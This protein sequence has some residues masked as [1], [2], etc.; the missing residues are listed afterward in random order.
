MRIALV[1]PE[2][3]ENLA[4]RYLHAAVERAGHEARI[5][6]FH[7]A[8]QAEQLAIDIAEYVPQLVGLSM[9]FTAR[10]KEFLALAGRLRAL[11]FAGHITAGGHFAAFHAQ[12]L[13]Q[14]F[15]ALDSVIQGEGEEALVELASQAPPGGNTG[16]TPPDADAPAPT[17]SA[18]CTGI[19]GLTWRDGA[20]HIVHTGRRPNPADLDA[21]ALPTRPATL[22]RYLGLPIANILA[23]RGCYGNCRFCSI[24]AWHRLSGGP[25]FRLR[26]VQPLAREMAELYH[27]RGVR[28]FNF[29]DDNFLVRSKDENLARLEALQRQLDA[30]AVGRIG[31]QI[32]A[33]PDSIDPDVVARLKELGL[34]RVFLGVETNAVA[35]LVTLGRG[36]RRR[37]NHEALRVLR[38]FG[39]HTCFNLLMFDPETRLGDLREN[40][41]FLGAQT[42]FPLNFCRVEVYAGTAIERQL[43]T[44][45]RLIGDYFGYSYRM[46]DPK[47][48]L[49][50]EVFRDVFYPRNFAVDGMNHQA[51]QVDYYFH[52]LRHFH[53][54]RVRRGMQEKVKGLVGELNRNSGELLER[55]CRF[56]DVPAAPAPEAV[57]RFTHEMA[58]RRERFD[59]RMGRRMHSALEA[60][61]RAAEGQP[62]GR[63]KLLTAAASMAAAAIIATTAGGA[64][65]TPGTHMHERAPAP[66]KPDT[67]P[68]EMAPVPREPVPTG[69]ELQVQVLARPAPKPGAPAAPRLTAQQAGQV[70]ERLEEQYADAALQTGLKHQMLGRSLSLLLTLDA[71]GKVTK[72]TI[73]LR[74]RRRGEVA[75]EAAFRRDFDELVKGW[76]FPDV[77]QAGT[78]ELGLEFKKA[79]KK[80]PPDFHIFEMAPRPRE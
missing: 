20:G 60:I 61:R 46:A 75:K 17:R 9:V 71:Q 27:D 55:I 16:Q 76:T 1:G 66:L 70:K 51:M 24:R 18:N 26:A 80:E 22:H 45:G 54:G 53:P 63:G 79:A 72:S 34:F 69:A 28:I 59:A 49:A 62:C 74:Q 77:K 6:D 40:I 4:L 11:G 13:L 3:E 73:V 50:Y 31:I 42:W 15:P 52:V 68:T 7:A 5:F 43:R 41:E 44:Q 56:V 48:Q 14:D 23:S 33:R 21:R 65:R 57:E 29:H 47:V 39:V 30:A 35:G 36:I 12:R 25:Q 78:C 58:A 64:E 2:L 67:H 19:L 8:Q 32:K 37:Q 38:E 10:A